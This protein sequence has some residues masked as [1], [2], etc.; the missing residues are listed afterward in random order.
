MSTTNFPG[1]PANNDYS[2][3]YIRLCR[4]IDAYPKN[5]NEQNAKT[6]SKRTRE[7]L[8]GPAKEVVFHVAASPL[9]SYVLTDKTFPSFR[10]DYYDY[11]SLF[12]YNASP[13]IA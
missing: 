2:P 11:H 5:C 8:A 4:A 7:W 3:V 10:L 13:D 1:L 12:D 9:K 6:W